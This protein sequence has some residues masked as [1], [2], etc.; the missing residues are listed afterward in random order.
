MSD[1]TS[2]VIRDLQEWGT[3]TVLTVR[4]DEMPELFAAAEEGDDDA[5]LRLGVVEQITGQ[6][7]YAGHP[8]I[9]CAHNANASTTAA[10]FFVTK[11]IV[12]GA[13]GVFLICCLACDN[14]DPVKLKARVMDR[15]GFRQLH[16][17]AGHG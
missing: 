1:E 11:E 2:D 15:L 12:P 4:A 6:L 13:K 8:C 16:H 7:V 14:P 5:R 17:Q 3:A 10:I 9:F